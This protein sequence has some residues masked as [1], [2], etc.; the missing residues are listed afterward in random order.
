[1]NRNNMIETLESRELFA[2]TPGNVP[3]FSPSNATVATVRAPK[4]PATFYGDIH[5]PLSLFDS[6]GNN[7]EGGMW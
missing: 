1:V 4:S 2:A 7:C 3:A 6:P 5:Q